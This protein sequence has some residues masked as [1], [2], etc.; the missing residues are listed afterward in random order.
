MSNTKYFVAQVHDLV[1]LDNPNDFGHQYAVA[2][3]WGVK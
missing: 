3:I 2:V 1:R